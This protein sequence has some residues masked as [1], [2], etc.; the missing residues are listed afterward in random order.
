MADP[1]V[2]EPIRLLGESIGFWIQTVA[3]VISALSA[4]L[5]ILH[6]GVTARRRATVDHIA[7]Q[8]FVAALLNIFDNG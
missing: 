7:H 3:F 5:I 6:N 8:K 2:Q 4:A 1:A